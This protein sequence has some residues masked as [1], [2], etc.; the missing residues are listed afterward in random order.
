MT[1]K[2]SCPF[3]PHCKIQFNDETSVLLHINNVHTI[4]RSIHYGDK[5]HGNGHQDTLE[6]AND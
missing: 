3:Y 1:D 6:I 2:I 5:Y 4:C